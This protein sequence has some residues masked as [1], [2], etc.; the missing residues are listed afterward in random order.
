MKFVFVSKK[1]ESLYTA[2]AGVKKYPVN[3]VDAFFDALDLIDSIAE[4]KELLAFKGFN[5]K[6]LKGQLKEFHSLRLNKQFRLLVKLCEDKDGQF[7]E[8]AQIIDYH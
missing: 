6:K 2:E 4:A 1:L 8:I 3:V 7:F 5:Y